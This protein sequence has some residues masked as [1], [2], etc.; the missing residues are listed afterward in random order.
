MV[1][2]KEVMPAP[3]PWAWIQ[4]VDGA[5]FLASLNQDPTRVAADLA[6]LFML[7]LVL[8]V[9]AQALLVLNSAPAGSA[10]WWQARGPPP[11]PHSSAVQLLALWGVTPRA[12]RNAANS[13]AKLPAERV[14]HA[15]Y[16]QSRSAGVALLPQSEK[17]FATKVAQY[18]FGL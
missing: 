3:H 17:S 5:T 13:G 12:T 16:D 10:P 8:T 18:V 6:S 11:W 15:V 9:C 4:G 14:L 1:T 7:L 2:A